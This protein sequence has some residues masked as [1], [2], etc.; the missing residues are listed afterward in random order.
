MTDEMPIQE[1]IERV[2]GAPEVAR[3]CGV[4]YSTPHSWKRVPPLHAVKVATRLGV[5]LA[6]IRAD[7][8]GE[9]DQ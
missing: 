2:G 1:I 7:M 5:P 6:R 9:T 3:L 4:H 8:L